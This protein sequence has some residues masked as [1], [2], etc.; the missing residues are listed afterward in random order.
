MGRAP[1][2]LSLDLVGATCCHHRRLVR[3]F[4]RLTHPRTLPPYPHPQDEILRRAVALL[5]GKCWKKIGE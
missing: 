1:F 4:S 2:F 5:G 3:L